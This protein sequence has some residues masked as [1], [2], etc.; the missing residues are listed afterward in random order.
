MY[1]SLYNL[2]SIRKEKQSCIENLSKAIISRD[3]DLQEQM[4]SMILYLTLRYLKKNRTDMRH[5]LDQASIFRDEV[6]S[7]MS[8]L[9]KAT[10]LG[11]TRKKD[12]IH[13]PMSVLY[14]LYHTTFHF[15]KPPWQAEAILLLLPQGRFSCIIHLV[16]GIYHPL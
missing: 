8:D 4:I 14:L 11:K 6:L 15:T 16:L 9:S 13:F 10:H 2:L 5:H 3:L 7:Q 1:A 12:G